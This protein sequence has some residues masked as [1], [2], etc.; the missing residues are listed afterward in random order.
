MKDVLK[1]IEDL[2]EKESI[3]TEKIRELQINFIQKELKKDIA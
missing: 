1:E 2:I 3:N